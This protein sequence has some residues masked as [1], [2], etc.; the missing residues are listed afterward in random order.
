MTSCRK[1]A[2]RHVCRLG[3]LS[4]RRRRL[5]TTLSSTSLELCRIERPSCTRRR[6]TRRLR[7]SPQHALYRRAGFSHLARTSSRALICDRVNPATCS[8]AQRP[9]RTRRGPTVASSS[10]E[11]PLDNMRFTA[12]VVL[13]CAVVLCL[14]GVVS[15]SPRHTLSTHDYGYSRADA[16]PNDVQSASVV[17]LH[18]STAC[19]ENET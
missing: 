19:E 2:Y 14:V 6:P 8:P 10:A 1:L 12:A 7:L 3:A 18:P 5:A 13:T 9:P 4:R 17:D 11:H 15:P 16:L